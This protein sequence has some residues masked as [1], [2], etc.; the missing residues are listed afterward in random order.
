MTRLPKSLRKKVGKKFRFGCESG[1]RRYSDY[2][3]AYLEMLDIAE[4]KNRH[5]EQRMPKSIY[6][7]ECCGGFHLSSKE[8]SWTSTS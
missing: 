7:C 2:G 6:R 4:R 1:K 5:G 8:N 3:T